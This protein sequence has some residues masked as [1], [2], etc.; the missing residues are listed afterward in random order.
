MRLSVVVTTYRR[1]TCLKRCL[2]GLTQQ[3]TQPKDI[4][5]VYRPADDP[6]TAQFLHNVDKAA[7]R[8]PLFAIPVHEPGA[9]PALMAGVTASDAE[10]VAA[11]DDDA[12]PR[13]DWLT[14]LASHY[15][16]GVGGV[17][18]RDVIHLGATTSTDS[19]TTVGIL[20]WYGRLIGNHHA[21]RGSPREVDTLKGVNLSFRRELWEFDHN[22]R[23]MGAQVHWEVFLC[24][25][26]HR[27]G[28][29]LIYDPAAIVD[30]YPAPRPSGDH[31]GDWNREAVANASYN[32]TLA[33]IAYCPGYQ[34]LVRVGYRL[35]VGDFGTPGPFRACL[36][37]VQGH[38]KVL[39]ATI[40]A[41]AG[42]IAAAHTRIS[43]RSRSAL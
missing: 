32:A 22:L 40:P 17:G 4:I 42:V 34:A 39:T 28:Y 11:T 33:L 18:G 3:E 43:H 38:P 13:S 21:G 15:R 8:V 12:I 25:Q 29:R 26:A 35:L 7:F 23:G 2:E 9:V 37:V 27:L 30:H 14:K 20:T 16:E 10:I 31:R 24:Q 5:V 6:R 19:A 1:L 41:M 36:A